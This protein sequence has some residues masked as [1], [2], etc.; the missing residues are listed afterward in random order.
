MI[1]EE[2]FSAVVLDNYF[3]ELRGIEIRRKI[4]N[5]HPQT[6][7]IFFSGEVRRAEIGKA[8]QAG[9]S[10]YLIKPND[11]EKLLE[12]TLGLIGNKQL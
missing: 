2:T 4:R 10:A 6:P 8:M 12:T 5:L 7:I 9:A 1:E 3:G 11:F